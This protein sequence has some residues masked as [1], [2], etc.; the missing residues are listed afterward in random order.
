MKLRE[1][2]A[3]RQLDICTAADRYMKERITSVVTTIKTVPI[4]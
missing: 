2:S 4:K 1:R 3:S